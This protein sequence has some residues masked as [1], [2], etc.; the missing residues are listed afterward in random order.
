MSISYSG[1]KDNSIRTWVLVTIV[2]FLL[3]SLGLNGLAIWRAF[4]LANDV[5]DANASVYAT[6]QRIGRVEDRLGP[7]HTPAESTEHILSMMSASL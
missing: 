3:I 7:V 2:V 1:H 4:S 6:N 5:S